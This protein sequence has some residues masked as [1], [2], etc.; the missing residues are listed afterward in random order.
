MWCGSIFDSESFFAKIW[1]IFYIQ[2]V[3]PTQPLADDA[4]PYCSGSGSGSSTLVITALLYKKICDIFL[5]AVRSWLSGSGRMK[6]NSLSSRNLIY[7]NNLKLALA[8][9]GTK[10]TFFL[11]Y[12]LIQTI[13]LIIPNIRKFLHFLSLFWL[14]THT[15]DKK[16]RNSL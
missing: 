14:Y 7:K 10:S 2:Y 3:Y 9:Y 15:W 5:L 13:V 4:A 8:R 1:Q 12:A 6:T 16:V 11:V